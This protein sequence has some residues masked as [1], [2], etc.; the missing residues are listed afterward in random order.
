MY[1]SAFSVKLKLLG[2]LRAPE[3]PCSVHRVM[4]LVKFTKIRYVGDLLP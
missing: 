2:H 1:A 3:G 4:C